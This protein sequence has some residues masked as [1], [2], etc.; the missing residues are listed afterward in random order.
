MATMLELHACA[1][2]LPHIRRYHATRRKR[3]TPYGTPPRTLGVLT[4]KWSFPAYLPDLDAPA[5][6]LKTV[7]RNGWI[8]FNNWNKALPVIA[9]IRE[10]SHLLSV[11]TG[12]GASVQHRIL[13]RF[14]SEN[15]GVRDL[16]IMSVPG[17]HFRG[18]AY[19]T[20][21]STHNKILI[22]RS[23]M[24]RLRPGRS[25]GAGFVLERLK[26]ALEHR[27]DVAQRDARN[28]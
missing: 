15:K 19:T 11:A 24:A 16:A 12:A 27:Q 17:L 20:K 18:L 8:Q 2:H 22:L 13:E 10:D 6:D 5:F 1:F 3:S 21:K 23:P 26:V 14:F 4:K 9:E 28:P 25:F 7:S